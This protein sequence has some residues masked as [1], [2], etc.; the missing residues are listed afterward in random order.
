MRVDDEFIGTPGPWK[1]FTSNSHMRLSSLSTG[2]DGDV[3]HAYTAADG[4]PVVNVKWQDA[5][6][7]AAA[8]ELLEALQAALSW[9]D[10]VPNDVTLPTMPGFDRDWVDGVISKA[11]GGRDE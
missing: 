3:I 4:V 7:I 11:F 8:P 1:W 2:R 5:E 9:I 10:A 6:L